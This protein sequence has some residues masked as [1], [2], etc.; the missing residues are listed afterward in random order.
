MP[1]VWL[2]ALVARTG[3]PERARKAVAW[4][5]AVAFFAIV[6]ALLVL[7]FQSW[8]HGREQ[9]AVSI[10]RA[11]VSTQ[12][13]E[14]VLAADRAATANEQQQQAVI[15]NNAE[16]VHAAAKQGDDSIAGPGTSSVLDRVRQQQRAGR[17]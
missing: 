11:D 2:I 9:T 5:A 1:P 6:A 14:R 8:I 3:I 13:A 16:E 10:D 4:L 17:R 7:A 12:A 15:A